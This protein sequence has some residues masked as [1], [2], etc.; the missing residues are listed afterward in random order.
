M[1]RRHGVGWGGVMR[2]PLMWLVLLSVLAW[3]IVR[4]VNC[5]GEDCQDESTATT[6]DII[7]G[8]LDR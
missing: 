2:M 1:L 4:L 7:G 8:G 3:A 6:T 5:P